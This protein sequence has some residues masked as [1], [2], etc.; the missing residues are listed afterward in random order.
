MH[1]EGALALAVDLEALA[2]LVSLGTLVTFCS[3]AGAVLWRR[4]C[5]GSPTS[6]RATAQRLGCIVACS[7][8][9]RPRPAV[10]PHLMR[11]SGSCI[12]AQDEWCCA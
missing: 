1:S 9:E 7:L 5:D 6:T 2:E 10:L 4:Y 3:T 8:C 12:A 11:S